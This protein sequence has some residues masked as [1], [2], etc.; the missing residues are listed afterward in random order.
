M[1]TADET[2]KIQSVIAFDRKTGRKLWQTT[3]NTGGFSPDRIH[4]KNTHASPTV[5][6]DGSRLFAGPTITRESMSPD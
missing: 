3:I 6:A 1:Q 5:A 4:R 2:A